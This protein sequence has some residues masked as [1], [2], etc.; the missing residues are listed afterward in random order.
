M[1]LSKCGASM[2]IIMFQRHI[3]IFCC[4]CVASKNAQKTRPNICVNARHETVVRNEIPPNVLNQ[5]SKHILSFVCIC[6]FSTKECKKRNCKLRRTNH[7]Q[8]EKSAKKIGKA[9][10]HAADLIFFFW[11]HMV[12]VL[13]HFVSV[14]QATPYVSKRWQQM[15]AKNAW[16]YEKGLWQRT[17]KLN[18]WVSQRELFIRDSR[19]Q[20]F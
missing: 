19:S 4:I 11:R 13:S 16:K 5:M 7:S 1:C 12:L 15:P 6:Y 3:A 18:R 8:N 10:Q 2:S 14:N 17:S 20:H 9:R